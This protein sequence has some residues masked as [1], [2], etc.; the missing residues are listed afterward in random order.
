V[1]RR[2]PLWVALIFAATG[3]FLMRLSF[4]APDVWILIFPAI[5]LQLWALIGRRLWSAMLVGFISATAFW[6]PLIFWLTLYLGP[7]PWLG[8]VSV[9]VAWMT[10]AAVGTSLITNALRQRWLHRSWQRMLIIP[11]SV[12]GLWT[13]REAISGSWPWGGFSWGRVA[14]SQSSSPFRTL[15]AWLGFA[16][17]SFVIVWLTA[18]I[19]EAGR[20]APATWWW[21]LP[22]AVLMSAL[23]VPA[24]Q[25]KLLGSERIAA[26]Q[27][28]SKSGLFDNQPPGQTLNDHIKVTEQLTTA[29]VDVIV[30]PENAA[31]ISP[32]VDSNSAN[33]LSYLSQ[34]IKAPI[35]TGAITEDASGRLFNSSLV[36]S[37][38][39][40][41]AQYDKIHPVPFA[42]W[43]PARAFFHAIVPD[44]VNL[45]T[46]DY[47]FGERPNVLTINNVPT[48]ISICFDIVDD[49]Q[50][51]Q[52]VDRGAQVVFAQTNNADFGATDESLQQ[53]AIAQLRSI[54]TG[55]SVVNI[56]TVGASAI[57][58]PTGE[59]LA[60]LPRF[61]AAAMVEDVPLATSTTPAMVV[62]FPLE[63]S[64]SALGLAAL[65]MSLLRRN[66]PSRCRQRREAATFQQ[67]RG[68]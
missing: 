14:E 10:S 41:S 40:I 55:L 18:L 27:G 68:H 11:L 20:M 21:A 54:E 33:A 46:R 39:H 49:A 23:L 60:S 52:M 59:T 37:G 9:M 15:I 12:A 25:P 5:F 50:I 63:L 31:D 57:F 58:S 30:W 42:E 64:V 28:N 1:I 2:V 29:G 35:V 62:G 47:S 51:R 3:G 44:L 43:M 65:I 6:A 67:P 8:L 4:P 22:V 61:T 7:I 45:V 16:G 53:I 13:A 17:V 38:N 32:L 34:K 56:S 66:D 24:W 36:W 48:G 26:I 19:V